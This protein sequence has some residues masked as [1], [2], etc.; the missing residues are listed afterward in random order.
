MCL[1][2]VCYS[3]SSLSD[4]KFGI[5]TC[6]TAN[7]VQARRRMAN[8]LNAAASA[9]THHNQSPLLELRGDGSPFELQRTRVVFPG[10]PGPLE[11]PA[12]NCSRSPSFTED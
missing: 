9:G 5:A 6:A 4:C 10:G 11:S 1:A 2:R 12:L 7:K 3:L 8:A